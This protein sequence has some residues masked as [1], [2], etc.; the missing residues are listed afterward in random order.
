MKINRCT[1]ADLIVKRP[2]ARAARHAEDGRDA[3][4]EKG[5]NVD[6]AETIS[7]VTQI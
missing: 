7:F 3:D 1:G 4:M 6:L 2:A 5:G